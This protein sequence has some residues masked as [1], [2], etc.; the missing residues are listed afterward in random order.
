MEFLPLRKR[1]VQGD[2]Q[3]LMMLTTTVTG[4]LTAVADCGLSAL[5]GSVLG[6]LYTVYMLMPPF[7]QGG[8]R[9]LI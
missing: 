9:S 2:V 7:Y 6:T 4:R 8:N 5:P 3:L 1:M